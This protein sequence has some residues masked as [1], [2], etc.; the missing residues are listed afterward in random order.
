MDTME[1]I[2]HEIAAPE[3]WPTAWIDRDL[4]ALNLYVLAV[5]TVLC[6]STTFTQVCGALRAFRTSRELK[7]N[8]NDRAAISKKI[9]R[10]AL[11]VDRT[12][13][14]IALVYMAN[15]FLITLVDGF[16]A[17]FVLA[18]DVSEH[19]EAWDGEML[20]YMSLYLVYLLA[21]FLASFVLVPLLQ[22][23]AVTWALTRLSRH[24]KLSDYVPQ[25]RSVSTCTAVLWTWASLAVVFFWPV[26]ATHGDNP[27]RFVVLEAVW[28]S[29]LAWMEA[30]FLF[31]YLSHAIGDQELHNGTRVGTVSRPTTRYSS[32]TRTD[33]FRQI[34]SMFAKA[35]AA[36]F[37][38]KSKSDVLP[39]Y[40]ET[41]QGGQVGEEKQPLL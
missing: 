26:L 39:R 25:A 16:I 21:L 12:L 28:G 19:P 30:A 23:L 34:V 40:E 17:A 35:A 6:V 38:N 10:N 11:K 8:P 31:N 20:F 27:M 13:F 32:R 5:I 24:N 18:K 7:N 3:G 9:H 2:H 1:K 22:M 33:K 14:M 41:A 29:A 37:T 36:S 4:P 15:A